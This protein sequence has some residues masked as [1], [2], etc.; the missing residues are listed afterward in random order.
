M[1]EVFSGFVCGFALSIITTPAFALWVLKA[2]DEVPFIRNA[3]PPGMSLTLLSIPISSFFF[4]LWTGLGLIL[5]ML[6]FAANNAHPNGGLGSPNLL[7]TLM[8]LVSAVI[9]F[10][11]FYVLIPSARRLVIFLDLTYVA[12]FGWATPLLAH[13][14]STRVS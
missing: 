9:I 3:L 13:Y 10:M 12:L 1:P 2:R 5:G 4:L 8:V 6:L 14:A 11:P 7:Y